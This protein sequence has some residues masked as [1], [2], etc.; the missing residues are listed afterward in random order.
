MLADLLEQGIAQ[1]VGEDPGETGRRI[2]GNEPGDDAE[3]D[4]RA[5][6]P[7]DYRLVGERHGQDDGLASKHQH[8][9]GNDPRLQLGLAFGPEHRKESEQGLY[10]ALR[11]FL[12]FCRRH[13]ARQ[14]RNAATAPQMTHAKQ[15]ELHGLPAVVRRN[16]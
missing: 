14:G 1:I 15:P 2:G 6:H 5:G 7:V 11:L 9:C 4:R 16:L 12:L 10:P 8:D 13:H 3:R